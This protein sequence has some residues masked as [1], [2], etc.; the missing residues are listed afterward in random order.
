MQRLTA[1]KYY[2][3]LSLRAAV[4]ADLLPPGGLAAGLFV[5]HGG[6][7]VIH[8]VITMITAV[9]TP[10]VTPLVTPLFTPRVPAAGLP[11]VPGP[12]LLGVRGPGEHLPPHARPQLP[13][14]TLGLAVVAP[15]GSRQSRG[16]IAFAGIIYLTHSINL[17]NKIISSWLNS[18]FPVIFRF[19]AQASVT[20]VFIHVKRYANFLAT[21]HKNKPGLT[22]A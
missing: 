11:R 6:G 7:E 10:L 18:K 20:F 17:E 3:V 12:R 4:R 21:L 1:A 16:L 22:A 2:L 13:P 8:V 15:G 19:M 14:E 9:I 5:A